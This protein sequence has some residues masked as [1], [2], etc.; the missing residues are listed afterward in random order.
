MKG[1]NPKF[2]ISNFSLESLTNVMFGKTKSIYL[3][4]V[5]KPELA[6]WRS[7]HPGLVVSGLDVSGP[8]SRLSERDWKR[9]D[10]VIDHRHDSWLT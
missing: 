8:G 9:K 10:I 6:N 5:F 4:T 3:L 2:I 7:T 1:K